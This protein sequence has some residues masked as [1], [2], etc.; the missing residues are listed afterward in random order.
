M[1]YLCLFLL[2]LLCTLGIAQTPE[3]EVFNCFEGKIRPEYKGLGEHFYAQMSALVVKQPGFISQTP[4]F[5][6][7]QRGQ[8]VLF[9]RFDSAEH[10]HAWKN[11][12]VHLGIQAKGRADVFSDYRLRIGNE[13]FESKPG[14]A[15]N[16][17]LSDG[18]Y[19][20]L[21]VSPT[22]AMI[23]ED[24]SISARHIAPKLDD[25]ILQHLVDAAT[26]EYDGSTLRIFSWPTKEIGLT[27]KDAV[28]RVE[29]DDLRLVRVE[30]D[31]GPFQRA[32][33][34]K[35]SD[36]CQLAAAMNDTVALEQC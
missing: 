23:V 19:L 28:P 34:P 6:V 11:N 31:Y 32:E 10:L 18:K 25:S 17:T 2:S 26:Y 14:D 3:D 1:L 21:W 13:A 27:V 35:D 36:R 7:D 16:S 15:D 9:V 20:L 12:H 29:G 24:D 30:R 4:F 22:P 33:A 8:Q 5:F